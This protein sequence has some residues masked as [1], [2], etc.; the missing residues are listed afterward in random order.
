VLSAAIYLPRDWNAKRTPS[1][2]AGKCALCT[3]NPRDTEYHLKKTRL[4]IG[5]LVEGVNIP[6]VPS[7]LMPHATPPGCQSSTSHIQR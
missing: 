7:Q 6:C 5:A 4:K 1:L 2:E 3:R